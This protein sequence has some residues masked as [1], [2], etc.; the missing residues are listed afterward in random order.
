M[1]RLGT[2]VV[3]LGFS[4]ALSAQP[5]DVVV[6]GEDGRCFSGTPPIVPLAEWVSIPRGSRTGVA[7][8][9]VVAQGSDGRIFAVAQRELVELRSP[10]ERL[11]L[12]SLPNGWFAQ[13]MSVD[14][15]GKAYVL[16]ASQNADI[17]LLL[18]SPGG[19][20]LLSFPLGKDLYTAMDLAADQCTLFM[21]ATTGAIRRFNVCT[22]AF[23][24]D[25]ASSRWNEITS[26]RVL[27]D[28]GILTIDSSQLV[29]Y[30]A[31]GERVQ[32]HEPAKL[33][34]V[35]TLTH[36][37]TRALTVTADCD[38][39]ITEIDLD[40]L[41][42]KQIAVIQQDLPM[43]VVAYFGWTAALGDAHHMHRR[44]VRN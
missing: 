26:L 16:A 15:A 18:F 35:M 44:S 6:A 5:Y 17:A 11:H 34:Y 36:G 3:A 31:N 27:P 29:R 33:P 32:E 13:A 2:A 43:S 14:R 41:T 28:G 42:Q 38:P 8:I 23:E 1:R 24:T 10:T 40:T 20:L 4:L 9:Q 7:N 37:G 25:F 12:G 19:T 21:A 39:F 30:A 22:G